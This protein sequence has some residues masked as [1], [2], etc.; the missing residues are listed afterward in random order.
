MVSTTAD[1]SSRAADVRVPSVLVVLVTRDAAAWLRDCLRALSEQTH[2]RL[3][4]IA[5]D[6]AS[7]DGSRELLEKALGR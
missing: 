4:V 2:P 6:N 7:E 1:R 5:V 3:G